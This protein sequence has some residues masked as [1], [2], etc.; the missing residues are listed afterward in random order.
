[1]KFSSP[2]RHRS[3]RDSSG[4]GRNDMGM[5]SNTADTQRFCVQVATDRRN[6]G[7]HPWPNVALQPRFTIFGAED[8]MNEDF[9]KR[10]RHCGIIAEKDAQVN[11]AVSATEFFLQAWGVAPGLYKYRAVGA[12][13]VQRFNIG[14]HA[15]FFVE[16]HRDDREFL[17]SL[18]GEG[19]DFHFITKPS[20]KTRGYGQACATA[21]GETFP[22]MRWLLSSSTGPD[23]F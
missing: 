22:F 17:S 3:L 14:Q 9:A 20:V 16:S 18:T 23:R 11:R 19:L 4:K 2:F 12:K 5:I 8:N 15:L 10:L 21:A 7:V 1:M 13:Q 6:I